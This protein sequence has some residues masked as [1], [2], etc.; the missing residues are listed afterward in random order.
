MW[1]RVSHSKDLDVIEIGVKWNKFY[2]LM[3][4]GKNKNSRVVGRL[5]ANHGHELELREVDEE[6]TQGNI[7]GGKIEKKNLE[8]SF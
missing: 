2:E 7:E 5:G 6:A 1:R 8:N 3:Q 4:L